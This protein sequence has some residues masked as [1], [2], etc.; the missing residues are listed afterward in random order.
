MPKFRGKP[1]VI[2]AEQFWPG[3]PIPRGVTL[4]SANESGTHGGSHPTG[5][6][7]QRSS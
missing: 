4:W 7:P 3:K 1:T 5:N 6:G 2:E